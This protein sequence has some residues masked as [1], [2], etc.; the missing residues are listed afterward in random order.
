MVP[1]ELTKANLSSTLDSA[2]IFYFDV[3]WHGTALFIADGKFLPDMAPNRK[4]I[5]ILF[6]L[7][8]SYNLC[9]INATHKPFY[10][11]FSPFYTATKTDLCLWNNPV[12]AS[13]RKVPILIDAER[14]ERG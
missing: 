1:E 13:Q 12:R 8:A 5:L 14:R 11:Y 6:M 3:R 2:N 4:V 9:C 10:G 7:S